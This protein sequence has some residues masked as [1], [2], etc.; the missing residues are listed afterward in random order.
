MSMRRVILRRLPEERE[1]ELLGWFAGCLVLSFIVVAAFLLLGDL[2]SPAKARLIAL[3]QMPATLAAVA[4]NDCG[5]A[6]GSARKA[7]P[8][9]KGQAA[10]VVAGQ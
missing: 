3:P 2:S 7:C 4:S 10:L 1:P 5:K 6:A 8:A 9:E